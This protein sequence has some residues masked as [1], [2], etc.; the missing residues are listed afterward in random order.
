MPMVLAEPV[1]EEPAG[2]GLAARRRTGKI[3]VDD[4]HGQLAVFLSAGDRRL[5]DLKRYQVGLI[6]KPTIDEV[7]VTLNYP[8]Y[9]GRAARRAFKRLP[10]W[11]PRSSRLPS[12]ASAPRSRSPRAMSTLKG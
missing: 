8:T 11:R 12:F 4:S 5:A 3:H 10:T 7:E 1:A 2:G 9:L 6:Q